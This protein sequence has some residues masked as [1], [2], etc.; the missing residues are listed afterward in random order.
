MP[1]YT[2]VPLAWEEQTAVNFTHKI[3]ITHTNM[4]SGW[5][6]GSA[7]G[8]F[9]VAANQVVARA[10]FRLVTAF[11]GGGTTALAFK[12]GD[13]NDDDRFSVSKSVHNNDTPV[14]AW[15]SNAAT[16]PYAYTGADTVDAIFTATDGTLAGLTAG[17][18]NIYLQVVDLGKV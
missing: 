17:E 4:D 8:I 11:S 12:L 9:T 6:S 16:L 2:A 10:A 7:L 5:T 13:G 3:T 18:I 1:T 15:S 14:T